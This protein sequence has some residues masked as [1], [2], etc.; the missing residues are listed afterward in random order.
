MWFTFLKTVTGWGFAGGGRFGF[1]LWRI[2]VD[3]LERV[4]VLLWGWAV[5]KWSYI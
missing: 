4:R 2:S 3:K 5:E 1:G